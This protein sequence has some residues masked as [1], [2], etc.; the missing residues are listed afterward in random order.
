MGHFAKDILLI[1]ERRR[2]HPLPAILPWSPGEH[3]VRL[4]T[5]LQTYPLSLSDVLMTFMPAM[6]PCLPCCVGDSGRWVLL[7]LYQWYS[8]AP[9]G[10]GEAACAATCLTACYS[11]LLLCTYLSIY[12]FLLLCSVM[13]K[14]YL[15]GGLPVPV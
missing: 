3:Y 12:Q 13:P 15:G 6:P 8:P 7:L 9:S 1:G 2:S 5:S 11:A 4:L 10:E 14:T